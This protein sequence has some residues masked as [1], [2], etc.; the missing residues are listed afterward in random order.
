MSVISRETAVRES[1]ASLRLE[2]LAAS[3]AMDEILDAWARHDLSDEDLEEAER[4]IC[5]GEPLTLEVLAAA[6][7]A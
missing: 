1:A 2:G 5:A 6:A 7:A 3:P 4:R